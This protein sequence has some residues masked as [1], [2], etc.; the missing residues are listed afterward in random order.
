MKHFVFALAVA[1]ASSLAIAQPSDQEK[2]MQSFSELCKLSHQAG[3]ME[4]KACVSRHF[5]ALQGKQQPVC[6][7]EGKLFSVGSEYQGSRCEERTELY[8][9]TVGFQRRGTGQAEWVKPSM[10]K[11]EAKTAPSAVKGW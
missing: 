5:E 3:T 11:E 6:I 7:Y 9:T 1:A 4:H 10:T 8:S 2:L